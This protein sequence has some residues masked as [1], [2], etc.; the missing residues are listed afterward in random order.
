[1]GYMLCVP[2]HNP[3]LTCT[4]TRVQVRLGLGLCTGDR[5][6]QLRG[7]RSLSVADTSVRGHVGAGTRW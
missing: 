6:T 2:V 1:M 4:G 3:N 7:H 5:Y